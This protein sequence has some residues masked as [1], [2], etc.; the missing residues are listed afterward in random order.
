[1]F[2]IAHIQGDKGQITVEVLG[3]ENPTATDPDDANWLEA[4]LKLKAGPFSGSLKLAMTT[5]ELESTKPEWIVLTSRIRRVGTDTHMSSTT[6][7][8]TEIPPETT[9]PGTIIHPH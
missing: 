7:Y 3:Y 4:I 5:I 1:M 9:A 6:L 8:L 2:N